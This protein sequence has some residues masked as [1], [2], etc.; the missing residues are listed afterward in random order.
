VTGKWWEY[1]GADYQRVIDPTTGLSTMRRVQIEEGWWDSECSLTSEEVARLQAAIRA[2]GVMDL[3]AETP[4]STT[5]VIGGTDVF[6]TFEVDGKRHRIHYLEGGDN[7]PAP[8]K[9][10]DE[11]MEDLV[12][13]SLQRWR[14][15][16]GLDPGAP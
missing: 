11:L 7:M 10:V 6:Y 5:G 4:P 3:P 16:K 8:I 2:S 13:N 12:F 1:K 14:R 9:V 15:E